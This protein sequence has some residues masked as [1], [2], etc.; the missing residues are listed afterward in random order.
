MKG[1][2]ASVGPNPSFTH[3]VSSFNL[4]GDGR[5]AP[6]EMRPYSETDVVSRGA[7]VSWDDHGGTR[8]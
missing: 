6:R 2:G 7:N 3:D 5:A 4:N 1:A 8:V